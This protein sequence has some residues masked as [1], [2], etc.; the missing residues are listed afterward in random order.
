MPTQH[1]DAPQNLGDLHRWRKQKE[2]Y[3]LD[4]HY[5]DQI[6]RKWRTI[7]KLAQDPCALRG[8]EDHN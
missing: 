3:V 8:I 7:G 6:N 2:A 5:L 4:D 1:S